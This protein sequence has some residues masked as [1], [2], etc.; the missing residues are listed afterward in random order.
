MVN[1]TK[2]KE[3]KWMKMNNRKKGEK[4][5]LTYHAGHSCS[6]CHLNAFWDNIKKM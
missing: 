1:K 4:T 3:I 5:M 2:Q 6:I